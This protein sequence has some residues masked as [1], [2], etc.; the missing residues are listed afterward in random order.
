[1]NRTGAWTYATATAHAVVSDGISTVAISGIVTPAVACQ[2]LADNAR[3][4]RQTRAM[5]QVASYQFSN[6]AVTSDALLSS[7]AAHANDGLDVPTALLVMQDQFDLFDGY[8]SLM[9]RRGI[10]RA[11]L[12]EWGPALSWAQR[13]AAVMEQMRAGS[14]PAEVRT[15]VAWRPDPR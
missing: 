3:W 9:A 10:C 8:S 15:G 14:R 6:V 4:L 2:V 13:Q 1:M 12:L 7:A 11:P 5:A